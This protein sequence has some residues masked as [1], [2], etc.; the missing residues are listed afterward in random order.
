MKQKKVLVVVAHPDDET[1]WMGGTLIR[2][3]VFSRKWDLT[4][5]SL[6]RRN[7]T[8]R[9]PKFFRVCQI[10]NAKGFMSDLEDEKLEEIDNNEV[11]ERIKEMLEKAGKKYDYVFTHGEN[12]EYGHIRHKDTNKAVIEMIKK[13]FISCRRLFF[14]AYTKIGGEC[15]IDLSAKKFINLNKQELSKKKELITMI[16][17]FGNGSFEETSCKEKE[18][19][20]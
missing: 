18:A 14:F 1:I 9:A 5:I 17:G 3:S 6:C 16:Y 15:Y 8:D 11:I 2:N 19:F 12:G 7:D 4:I 20:K 10:L 13:K